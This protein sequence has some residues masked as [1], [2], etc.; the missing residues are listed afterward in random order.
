MYCNI[1][2][3]N[4]I[5]L[6][7]VNKKLPMS[8]FK[9][10]MLGVGFAF[11]VYYITKKDENGVSMLDELLDNPSDFVDRAKKYAIEEAIVT[12]QEKIA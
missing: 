5:I 12:V 7:N 4:G 9:T 3:L 11:G 1:L 10:F 2:Q 8:H 6:V